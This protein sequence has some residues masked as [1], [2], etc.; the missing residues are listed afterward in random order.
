MQ[1]KWF[2]MRNFFLSILLLLNLAACTSFGGPVASNGNQSAAEYNPEAAK[3]NVQ[4]AT[5]Y[6]RQGYNQRALEVLSKALVQNPNSAE[7]HSAL[8]LA[9]R[10][11]DNP[12]SA[13]AAY[14]KAYR[15]GP[16]NTDIR[17]QYATFLCEQKEFDQ[18]E[19]LLTSGLRNNR[20]R[21]S[22]VAYTLLGSCLVR[23]GRVGQAEQAFEQALLSNAAY[24]PAILQLAWLAQQR[25]QATKALVLLQRYEKVA[26]AT[27][28]SLILG[29]RAA[30]A[31]GN[32]ALA[33]SYDQRLKQ[34][35]PEAWYA[36]RDRSP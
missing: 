16:D 31:L 32:T 20:Y 28:P 17:N 34:Q 3:I 18:A 13:L 12:E 23:A 8:A 27:S 29:K 2:L 9:H 36:E 35:F 10:Q 6:L 1:R 22:E 4:L 19:A 5:G 25:S 21:Y 15:L 11:L 30:Q 33:R 7:V 24:G 14:R 26:N